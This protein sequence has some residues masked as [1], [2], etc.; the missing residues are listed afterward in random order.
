MS[1]REDFEKTFFGE[2]YE[3]RF[4]PYNSERHG[5]ALLV[6]ACFD[7]IDDVLRAKDREIADLKEKL[8]IF[9]LNFDTIKKAAEIMK[10]EAARAAS[11]EEELLNSIPQYYTERRHYGR[12]LGHLKTFRETFR[13]IA[14]LCELE[15]LSGEGG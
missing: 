5:K 1:H 11:L 15:K 6:K 14:E 13:C 9:E 4:S 3:D 12:H 10:T 8:R 7:H 2:S